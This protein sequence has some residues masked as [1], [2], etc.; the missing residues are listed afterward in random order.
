M[1]IRLVLLVAVALSLVSAGGVASA[2]TLCQTNTASCSGAHV[3]P[4]GTTITALLGSG[5][6]AIFYAAPSFE[7][8]SSELSGTTNAQT[9]TPLEATVK[10]LKFTSCNNNCSAVAHDLSYRFKIEGSGGN[11]T[12]D[13]TALGGTPGVKIVCSGVP[14]TYNAAS[15]VL[16]IT[17]GSPAILKASGLSLALVSGFP[18]AST[19]NWSAYYEVLKPVALYVTGP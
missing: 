15:Q 6:N 7:C 8:S 11:G 5:S 4:S 16:A 10:V 14:C 2:T 13:M 9:G 1:R 3:H 19:I 17:G 12:G 18:C